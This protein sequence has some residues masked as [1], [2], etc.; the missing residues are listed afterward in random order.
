FAILAYIAYTYSSNLA[1]I[2]WELWVGLLTAVGWTL[3]ARRARFARSFDWASAIASLVLCGYIA[4]R[5][6]ELT[7][8]FALLPTDRINSSVSLILLVLEASRRISGY[9]FVGVILAMAIYIYIS[10][11]LP[12]DFQTRWVT[13]ERAVTYLGLDTNSLISSILQVAVLVVIPFTIL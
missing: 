3:L 8:E 10:P 5:Y 6:E 7:Y 11:F 1:G 12:G 2:P 4:A 13:P 9:G